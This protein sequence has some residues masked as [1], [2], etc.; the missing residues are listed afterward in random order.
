LPA[1]DNKRLGSIT[2]VAVVAALVVVAGCG[3]DRP[4]RAGATASPSPSALTRPYVGACYDAPMAPRSM[5]ADGTQP[6][7]CTEQHRAETYHAGTVDA[8]GGAAQ[9]QPA[10]QQMFDLFATCE[11][12]A[13]TFLGADWHTGRIELLLTLPRPQDWMAGVRAYS[14]EAVEIDQPGERAA[15]RR[16]SSLRGSLATPG[17]LTMSCFDM[18]NPPNWAPMVPVACDQPHHAEYAGAFTAKQPTPGD[19]NAVLQAGFDSCEPIIDAYVGSRYNRRISWGYIG[20]DRYFWDFG[21]LTT[22]CFAVAEEGKRFTATVKGIGTRD[23]A[24]T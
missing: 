20:W 22:R 6:V 24:T 17:P 4:R 23:P 15:V 11:A 13:K 3:Q 9:V 8:P 10:S 5:W 14:C 1:V 18:R 19:D 21:Q 16:T 12:Q 2:V 7:A